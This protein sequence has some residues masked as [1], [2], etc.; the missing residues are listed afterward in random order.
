MS[1]SKLLL[2]LEPAS[3]WLL[4]LSLSVPYFF[5]NM[6]CSVFHPSVILCGPCHHLPIFVFSL[7]TENL[8]ITLANQCSS[9][10]VPPVLFSLIFSV[11]FLKMKKKVSLF[12]S[13]P[14]LS[15][16]SFRWEHQYLMLILPRWYSSGPLAHKI[17]TSKEKMPTRRWSHYKN[18]TQ[19]K[20]THTHTCALALTGIVLMQMFFFIYNFCQEQLETW[21][22]GARAEYLFAGLILPRWIFLIAVQPYLCYAPLYK[23]CVSLKPHSKFQPNSCPTG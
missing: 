19:S 21:K 11:G 18:F 7:Q 9:F 10:V 20:H 13:L 22:N 3:F 12:P 8:K 17:F 15:L 14:T 4:S 2:I 5:E 23:H 6:F 1:E 16:C